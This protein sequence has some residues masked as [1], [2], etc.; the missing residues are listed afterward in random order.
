[1]LL[2]NSRRKAGFTLVEV[3]V[4]VVLSSL[5]AAMAMPTL[6]FFS[7]SMLGV[8][9][10]GEMSA[11]SRSALEIFSRD[12]HTAESI[13]AASSSSFTVTLPDELNSAT[14]VY[15]YSSAN[16]EL[17]RM[18]TPAS[19]TATSRVL[20]GDVNRFAFVYYNRLGVDVTNSASVLT[21]SKSVQINAELLKEVLS[22]ANTDYII[23]ARF[24][25]R[26]H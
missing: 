24:L 1:M 9:N 8:G 18:E 13:T 3:M 21:E 22:V 17:T 14:V 16:K 19:G 23:S 10:Y 12:L 5:I 25:M 20:F 11:K 4:V 26:N 6:V 7:K 15:T 2:H